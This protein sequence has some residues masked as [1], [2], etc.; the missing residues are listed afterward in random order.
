MFTACESLEADVL[1]LIPSAGFYGSIVN[2]PAMFRNCS[3]LVC[4]NYDELARQLWKSG[5][6]FLT[7]KYSGKDNSG[8]EQ[9]LSPEIVGQLPALMEF[10]ARCTT[11]D[12]MNSKLVQ[13][14]VGKKYL[15][16]NSTSLLYN[17]S[18]IY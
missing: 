5:K 14:N 9:Q 3:K 11:V 18:H 17:N 1:S 15:F 13:E 2:V 16:I 10:E 6:I 7:Y 12:E 8:V 4:S